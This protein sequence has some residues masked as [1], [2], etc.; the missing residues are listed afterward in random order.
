MCFHTTWK[1]L[2]ATDSSVS[3]QAN[4]TNPKGTPVFVRSNIPCAL[5][6]EHRYF[7]LLIQ[8]PNRFL[9]QST[10]NTLLSNQNNFHLVKHIIPHKPIS[11][12]NKQ[13][14]S[15][16]GPHHTTMVRSAPCPCH[17]PNTK[18]DG[19]TKED[20]R[21]RGSK[22]QGSLYSNTHTKQRPNYTTHN[23]TWTSQLRPNLTMDHEHPHHCQWWII[24]DIAII[25]TTYI[26]TILMFMLT[27]NIPK[28]N[29][30]S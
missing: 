7:F 5:S 27:I 4:N 14:E 2:H 28:Y 19:G 20:Q 6:R 1:R 23:S 13:S 8:V 11:P 3:R 21:A 29:P 9:A 15:G 30:P 26:S 22:S 10:E 16:L 24:H 17:L 25:P 12:N 18:Q